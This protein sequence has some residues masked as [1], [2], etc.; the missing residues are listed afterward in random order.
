MPIGDKKPDRL[1]NR[2]KIISGD[3]FGKL[4]LYRGKKSL[5]PLRYRNNRKSRFFNLFQYN[6]AVLTLLERNRYNLSAF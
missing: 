2:R 4:Q 1:P 3:K 5:V 6:T